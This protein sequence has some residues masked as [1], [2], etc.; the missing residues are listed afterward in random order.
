M[1]D[2][3][4]KTGIQIALISIFTAGAFWIS[5]LTI[6]VIW[7]RILMFIFAAIWS[8]IAISWSVAITLYEKIPEEF[9][10]ED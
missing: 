3:V 1:T 4:S 10:E 5:A 2:G 7:V 9:R 8:A 6:E